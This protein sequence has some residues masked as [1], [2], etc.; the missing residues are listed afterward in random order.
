[1]TSATEY[2]PETDG[3]GN[4]VA[5]GGALKSEEPGPFTVL[6]DLRARD[7]KVSLFECGTVGRAGDIFMSENSAQT[8]R[9]LYG[10]RGQHVDSPSG[11]TG[12]RVELQHLTEWSRASGFESTVSSDGTRTITYKPPQPETATMSDGAVVQL[13]FATTL[14]RPGP[15]GASFRRRVAI[16]VDG[17]APMTFR[18]VERRYEVPLASLITLC[19]LRDSPPNRLS[20]RQDAG[21]WMEALSEV[22]PVARSSRY[23]AGVGLAPARG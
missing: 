21:D 20:V 18:E 2:W 17:F 3:D 8:V 13:D 4:V 10:L 19:L 9:P 16:K 23:L 12:V 14:G 15:G 5:I 1:M 11:I 6:G 22:P 7:Q